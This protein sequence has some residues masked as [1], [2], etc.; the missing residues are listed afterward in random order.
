MF[1]K[2][3]GFFLG[4]MLLGLAAFFMGAAV[5]LPIA[6]QVINQTLE[7][8]EKAAASNFLYDELMY[9]NITGTPSGRESIIEDGNRYEVEVIKIEGDSMWEVCILYDIAQ[10]RRKKC[11]STE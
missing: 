4:E 6:I 8:E 7:S 11:A 10:E 2:N 3:D 1:W 5:L 9:L